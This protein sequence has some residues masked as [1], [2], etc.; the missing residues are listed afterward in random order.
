MLEMFSSFVKVETALDIDSER[1]LFA[2]FLP[3]TFPLPTYIGKY[4]TEE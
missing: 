4:Y 2:H 1:R 3:F